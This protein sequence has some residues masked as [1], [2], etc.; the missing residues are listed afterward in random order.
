V[1]LLDQKLQYNGKIPNTDTDVKYRHRHTTSMDAC[2]SDLNASFV[3]DHWTT[4][5]WRRIYY[6]E[7]W[8]GNN[9]QWLIIYSILTLAH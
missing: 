6:I 3:T 5:S 7:A 9:S 2:T 8:F 1:A 4:Q